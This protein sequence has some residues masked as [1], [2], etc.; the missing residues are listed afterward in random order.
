MNWP[1]LSNDPWY[2]AD[3]VTGL[4]TRSM[5]ADPNYP[6]Y[7]TIS[8]TPSFFVNGTG[9]G[10]VTQA[11]MTA[12]LNHNRNLNSHIWLWISETRQSGDTILM[13]VKAVAD[14]QFT[15]MKLRMA[16]FE[17][18][19]YWET[20]APNGQ[21]D[22]DFPMVAFA[23]NTEG[24]TFTHSGN[25]TDTLTFT[26][27]FAPR[28]T[29]LEPYS[30]DNSSVVAWVRN[31]STHEVLQAEYGNRITNPL[32]TDVIYAGQ[33]TT[34]RWFPF[35]T[36][37]ANVN[38]LI[39]R[40]YPGTR[41]DTVALDVPNN[42]IYTWASVTGP[43]CTHGRFKIASRGTTWNA[44][45]S[46]AD[47]TI[48]ARVAITCTPSTVT[49]NMDSAT[50]DVQT[51]TVQNTDTSM[52]YGNVA[53]HLGANNYEYLQTADPG[54]PAA[55]WIDISTTGLPG[56]TGTDSLAGPYTMP[57]YYPLYGVPYNQLWMC[58]NGWLTFNDFQN[59]NNPSTTFPA[60]SNQSM[61]AVFWAQLNIV[62]GV[63]TARVLMDS[64][65]QRVIVSWQGAR[66]YGTTNTTIDAQI[67]LF[68]NGTCQYNYRTINAPTAHATVGAQ[69][70]ERSSYQTIYRTSPTPPVVTVPSNNAIHFRYV[71]VW[72]TIDRTTFNIP[73]TQSTD[74]QVSLDMSW[75]PAGLYH[76]SLDFGGNIIPVSVPFTLTVQG[77]SGAKDPKAIPSNFV[78]ESVYPN[79]FN[80]T[81]VVKFRMPV[82]STVSMKL[83]D[84]SGRLAQTEIAGK[85]GAGEHTYTIH[86]ENLSTGTYFLKFTAGSNYSVVKKLV[87]IK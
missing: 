74:L 1:G 81:T 46:L 26:G 41:W 82:A 39:N 67:V 85:M 84:V 25:I 16:L 66:L 37:T 9:V 29:G 4:A 52:Y 20:Q 68:A 45:T 86:G 53:V 47:L 62:P 83:Y 64:V 6:Q 23:P 48:R 18:H 11:L 72:G 59:A 33:P 56:P 70:E 71:P 15:N 22:F 17:R 77:L 8:S 31:E 35:I 54:G 7:N 27:R 76:G 79:P 32:P 44:D 13:T 57:F 21:T 65:N 73:R 2:W 55:Q 28:T 14:S 5:Y 50:Q 3:S 43:L 36:D 30:M 12:A 69:N 80:P 38:I 75:M 51:I 19:E 60:T 78:L 58:T 24:L 10:N 63:G 87:L 49:L 40:T 34:I 42:G 61:M